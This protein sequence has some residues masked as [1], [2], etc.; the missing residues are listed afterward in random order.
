MAE[1]YTRRTRQASQID[2]TYGHLP[3]Q[4]IEIEQ[5]VLGALLID[6][7]AFGIVSEILSPETFYDSRHKNIFTAI[8]S[9]NMSERPTD[10]L[11]VT[12]E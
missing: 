8:R 9:L 5:V 10:I 3:P 4:A 2:T 11:T 7:E 6:T 12:E 1:N